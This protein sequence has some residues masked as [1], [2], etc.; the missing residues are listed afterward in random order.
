MK[1]VLVALTTVF[2]ACTT[3]AAAQSSA[4][5]ELGTIS[6]PTSAKGPAQTAFLVGVK[7]LHNFEFDTAADAFR[8]AQTAD[9]GFALAY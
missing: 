7:A 3:P 2:V 4:S 1:T 8:A 9:S 6:F 5:G